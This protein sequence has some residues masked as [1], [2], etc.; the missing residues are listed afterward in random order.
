MK[1]VV[2][3]ARIGLAPSDVEAGDYLLTWERTGQHGLRYVHLLDEAEAR[4][5]AKSAGL[6]VIDVLESDGASG[7]LAEYVM[8]MKIVD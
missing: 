2:G 6:E 8:S 4:E 3:W 5:L 1:R 7:V